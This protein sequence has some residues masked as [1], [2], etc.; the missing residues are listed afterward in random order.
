MDAYWEESPV[1]LSLIYSQ[2]CA[3]AAFP[4]CLTVSGKPTTLSVDSAVLSLRLRGSKNTCS[5]IPILQSLFP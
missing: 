1:I 2:V 5:K 4:K 3:G